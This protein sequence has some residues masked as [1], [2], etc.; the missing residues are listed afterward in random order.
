LTNRLKNIEFI[1]KQCYEWLSIMNSDCKTPEE[2]NQ[3]EIWLAADEQHQ[4]VYQE[5]NSLW[6]EL[7][8][9][10]GEIDPASYQSIGKTGFW[11]KLSLALAAAT[12]PIQPAVGALSLLVAL[13]VGLYMA[14]PL[15]LIK[16]DDDYSTQTAEIRDIELVDNSIVTLGASSAIEVEFTESE[17]RVELLSGEAFF[18]VEK[19]EARPFVVKVADAEI[20]VV[21]TKF[22]V[23]R[24]QEGVR[25][26]VLEGIVEVIQ[27]REEIINGVLTPVR[28]TKIVTAEEKIRATP[29]GE[30]TEIQPIIRERLGAWRKG[31]L[32]Y[33]D[34][35]LS[36]VISDADRYFSGNIIIDTDDLRGL[37]VSAAF[38]TD[39]I[40]E[41][42]KTLSMVLPVSIKTLSN[43]DIVI[44]RRENTRS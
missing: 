22:D 1:E 34:A 28:T 43:G 30:L 25:V 19:D 9:L 33:E 5:V 31:R 17:R 7:P 14:D 4:Q 29:D 44:R 35:K 24:S 32:I 2:V 36:E 37:P 41:M 16:K 12:R 15:S 42:M 40:Q 6:S 10:Q 39:Q 27:T 3:F 18:S 23:R 8:A 21:G 13:F 11:E 38:R 26:S 20:R